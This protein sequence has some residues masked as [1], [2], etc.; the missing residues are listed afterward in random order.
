MISSNFQDVLDSMAGAAKQKNKLVGDAVTVEIKPYA[1]ASGRSVSLSTTSN[2]RVSSGCRVPGSVRYSHPNPL[3][4][5][6]QARC[7]TRVLSNQENNTF[8]GVHGS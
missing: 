3:Q 4:P 8:L 1:F 2:R 6:S 7:T 5:L